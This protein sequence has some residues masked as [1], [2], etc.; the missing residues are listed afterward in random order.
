M[1]SAT[2]DFESRI[3]KVERGV[4]TQ[5]AVCDE[6]FPTLRDEMRFWR[7]AMIGVMVLL[8][9]NVAGQV[10][11][12]HQGRIIREAL[13]RKPRSAYLE[14]QYGICDGAE[15]TERRKPTMANPQQVRPN[16]NKG[17]LDAAKRSVTSGGKMPLG[18]GDPRRVLPPIV[19]K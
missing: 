5:R 3:G 16:P 2:A 9:C 8:A 17:T 13:D 12:I 4:A 19:P 18:A 11:L 10:T 7:R 14:S 15:P 1:A 6:R